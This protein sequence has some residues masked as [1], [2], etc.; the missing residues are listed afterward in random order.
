[1]EPAVR[2]DILPFDYEGKKLLAVKID[3][4]AQIKSLVTTSRKDYKKGLIQE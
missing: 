3:E 4:I 2:P 1:M